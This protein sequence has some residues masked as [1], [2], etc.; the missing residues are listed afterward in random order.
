MLL[1][2]TSPSRLRTEMESASRPL[3][4]LASLR[5]RLASALYESL[6]LVGVLFAGFL[7]PWVLI[8][9]ALQVAPPGWLAWSHVGVLLGGYFVT[10]WRRTGQTLAMQTWQVQLVDASTGKPPSAAQSVARYLLA[11]PSSVLMLS[12][13]GLLWTAFV[14]RDRQFPHDRLA[15]TRIVFTPR[16]PQAA[17]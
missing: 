7:L 3:V 6:L 10:L 13:L 12:G 4:E 9:M 2:A 16:T 1:R 11:W 8:G 17:S 15:G 5:R 14:D